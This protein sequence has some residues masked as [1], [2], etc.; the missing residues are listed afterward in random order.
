M[1]EHICPSEEGSLSLCSSELVLHT[2]LHYRVGIDTVLG[3]PL[4][5]NHAYVG[6]AW[7]RVRVY[8]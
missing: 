2:L 5:S 3:L 1:V 4:D 7:R 6:D 8:A